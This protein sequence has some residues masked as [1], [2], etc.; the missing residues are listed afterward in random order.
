MN[1]EVD[2]GGVFIHGAL[3]C[4]VLAGLTVVVGRKFMGNLGIYAYFFN[5][6]LV[7]LCLFVLSWWAWTWI[8]LK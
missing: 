5:P 2:I 8:W 1:H 7:D 3:I 4:A 6:G